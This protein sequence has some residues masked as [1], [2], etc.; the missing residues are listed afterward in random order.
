M[1]A[2]VRSALFLLVFYSGTVPIV[3]LGAVLSPVTQRAVWWVS[4]TWAVWFVWCARVLV[5]VR[6]VVRGELPQAASI[7]AFK[8]QSAFETFLTLYL[9]SPPGGG[10]E[11]GATAVAGLGLCLGASRLDLRGAGGSSGRAVGDD[12][13]G[14]G[15]RARRP[16]D[17]YLP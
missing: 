5:G 14:A 10:D 16:A 13:A 9:F 11:G 3:L 15:G 12:A 2:R 7:I 1:I 8:H 6:L 4:H 17:R